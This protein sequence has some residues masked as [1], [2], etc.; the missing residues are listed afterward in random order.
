MSKNV[1]FRFDR[2]RAT[3]P[4]LFAFTALSA[5]GGE[6]KE[7]ATV[8]LPEQTPRVDVFWKDRLSTPPDTET[9]TLSDSEHRHVLALAAELR[10]AEMADLEPVLRGLQ[11]IGA[12]SIPV[13]VEQLLGA[14]QESTRRNLV[15][16]LTALD[17][18]RGAGTLCNLLRD[19]S[20]QVALLAA[21]GLGQLVVPWTLPR[22]IK[23]VG[24]Y[25]VTPW[26]IV[27]VEAAAALLKFKNFSGV[28]FLFKVLKEHTALEDNRNRD[29]GRRTRIVFEKE[30]ASRALA[31]LAGTDHGYSPNGPYPRQERA[32]LEMEHW[33]I[34]QRDEL[35]ATAPPF[36]DPELLRRVHWLVDGLA[37][38]QIRTVDNARFI[39]K[40]LGPPALPA[41]ERHLSDPRFYVRVHLLEALSRMGEELAPHSEELLRILG[42]HLIDPDPAIRTQAVSILGSAKLSQARDLLAAALSDSDGSVRVAAVR[43]L[44]LVGSPDAVGLLLPLADST[45]RDDLRANARAALFRLGLDEALDPLLEE[46]LEPNLKVQ[47]SA[48]EALGWL[49][50]PIAEFPLAASRALREPFPARIRMALKA[51]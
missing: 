32:I 35:W 38:Y 30:A 4:A 31:G 37:L 50:A 23:V 3:R 16:A 27:R 2:F 8:G 39:L 48:L 6:Q 10:K 45:V 15:L 19:S 25:D 20:A 42:P 11:K 5:C 17:D 9:V 46:L 49:G 14:K 34:E 18:P 29:W 40:S 7:A 24:R 12:G 21:R 36:T 22:L 33:W 41:F 28:P 44:G 26:L 43:S 47:A 51:P 13:L 1:R